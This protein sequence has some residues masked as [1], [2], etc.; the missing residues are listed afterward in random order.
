[1]P[2]LSEKQIY[3]I[4]TTLL[5]ANMTLD[6]GLS[7]P[8]SLHDQIVNVSTKLLVNTCK[9]LN[10]SNSDLQFPYLFNVGDLSRV[11][12]VGIIYRFFW[13]LPSTMQ[14]QCIPLTFCNISLYR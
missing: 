1:M 3:S 4:T 10:S 7:L 12:Q 9:M 5:E 11:F 14:S 6:Q 2:L 8:Q 13:S